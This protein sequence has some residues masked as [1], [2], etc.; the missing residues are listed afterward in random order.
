MTRKIE[1]QL[2]HAGIPEDEATGAVNIPIYQTSTYHQTAL[3]V[4]KGWEYSRTGNPTRAALEQ[5]IADLEHG[6]HGFAF[7]SGL[8]ALTTILHLFSSG[9]EI[10]ISENVYGGTYRLLANV[11]DQTGLKFSIVDTT[12]LSKTEEA[13]SRHP[14]AIL[15]ES[16]ANPLL[17]ITDVEA[18]AQAAHRE[19]V[20]VIVDS[21]F[22]TPYLM[23]PLDLGADIG[24]HSATK[25]L[26][27]H[28]DLIAGLAVVK[29]EELAQKLAFLQNAAG[30]VLAPFDSYL[31]IR[32]IRTL[33]VR[34]DRHQENTAAIASFLKESPAVKSVYY[35]GFEDAQGHEIQKKQASGF[36]A[37][38]SF[39]LAEE[40]DFR[41]FLSSLKLIYLA[42]SLGGVESLI[43]HPSSMTHASIPEEI[44]NK[45]GISEQLLRLSV[46]IEHAEDLIEDLNQA[47]EQ[48]RQG[49]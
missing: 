34:M 41:V 1:T 24:V 14:S 11:F 13:L 36:G 45:V 47:F 25:Y 42:E 6:T 19:G 43:C 16:P 8:A 23:R 40:Y 48:S 2:I 26:G 49:E 28:S 31:L 7:A 18:V 29:D 9:D 20:L 44:R 46:G 21:T 4:H 22:M 38:I 32:G 37:M 30:A 15:I 27:G 35:P 12:D 5:L 39:E 33:G 10:L 17:T 3:G